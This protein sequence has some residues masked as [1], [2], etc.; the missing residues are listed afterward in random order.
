MMNLSRSA[1]WI[2]C[3]LCACCIMTAQAQNS[4]KVKALKRQKTELQNKLKKSQQELQATKKKVQSGQRD[5]KVIG[6]KLEDRLSHIHRLESEM[7][8]LDRQTSQIQRNI[9]RISAQLEEKKRKFRQAVRYAR[10]CKLQSSP[11]LFVFSSKTFSQLFRRARFAREYAVYQRDLGNQILRRQV[12][13]LKLQNKLLESKSRKNGLLREVMEQRRLLGQQQVAR[14]KDVEGLQKKEKGLSGTVKEQQRQLAA[15]DKKIDNLIAYEIE[16]ARK[17]AEEAARKKA[18]EEARRKQAKAKNSKASS[19]SQKTTSTEKKK[20]DSETS[21]SARSGGSWLTAQDRQL[22]GTFVQNKGRL[23]VPITGSYMIGNHFGVYNVKGLKNVQLDNKG[24]NYVGQRGARARSIFDG[25]VT[26]VFQFGGTKNVLVRHG[27]Y[28]SVYCNLSSV[29][30]SKGQKVHTRDILGT[31]AD[32]GNGSCVLHFQ[33]RQETTKLN[34]ER[35][36]GR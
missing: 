17:R 9:A 33:L 12:E 36:I 26:A 21:S 4:K 1:R 25:V 24:T 32:D 18:A 11:M 15:L 34:P 27:S 14:Q 19:G 5:I 7:A 22:N 3:L 28:I 2:A 10:V 20:K 35:W 23:P 16:Q 30:V 29:I 13:L 8:D 31:V 6:Q